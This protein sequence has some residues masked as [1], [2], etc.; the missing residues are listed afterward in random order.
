MKILPNLISGLRI[1]I[2]LGLFFVPPLSVAFLI[3]YLLCG[4]SDVL[5]GF[6]ARRLH[7]ESMLGSRLDSLADFVLIGV[8]LWRLV[9]VVQP[10]RSVLYWMVAIVLLRLLAAGAARLRFGR[11]G[12]LHTLGNKLTGALLFLYPMILTLHTRSAPL[13]LLCAVATLSAIE[14]L[15]IELTAK[16]WNLDCKS[17]LML[18]KE[19]FF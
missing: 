3:I 8:L 10:S 4:F 6:L 14:E 9:P 13:T 1:L 12:F 17:I 5:D 2:C 16:T 19:E 15:P 18:S 7:A 11:W